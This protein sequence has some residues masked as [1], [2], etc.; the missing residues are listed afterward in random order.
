MH[1]PQ[2]QS[3]S[4]N[5]KST[6]LAL[7][8]QRNQQP[9]STLCTLPWIL[10]AMCSLYNAQVLLWQGVVLC[11]NSFHFPFFLLLRHW[12]EWCHACVIASSGHHLC[13][14]WWEMYRIE[15]EESSHNMAPDVFYFWR[16]SCKHTAFSPGRPSTWLLYVSPMNLNWIKNRVGPVRKAGSFKITGGG[17]MEAGVKAI[18]QHNIIAF[19]F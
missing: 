14:K 2:L 1:A 12:L 19:I 6:V 11:N 5:W 3:C 16:E 13:I 17:K 15:E 18:G 10:V 4:A 9:A 8:K 7:R